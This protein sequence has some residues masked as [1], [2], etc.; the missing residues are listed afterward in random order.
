MGPSNRPPPI[1]PEDVPLPV[2]APSDPAA[3]VLGIVL[4]FGDRVLDRQHESWLGRIGLAESPPNRSVLDP[5]R[6]ITWPDL[7]P[8]DS[9]LL[10]P[11]EG[12]FVLVNRQ[13]TL[14]SIPCLCKQFNGSE[15][16]CFHRNPCYAWM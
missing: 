3:G 7:Q 2:Q 10:V 16:G 14:V 13:P 4:C 12:M 6:C 9:I 1:L 11:Q 5:L 15:K 8:G